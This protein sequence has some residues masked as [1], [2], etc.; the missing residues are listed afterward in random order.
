[1][2]R[3]KNKQQYAGREAKKYN[4]PV[5]PASIPSAQTTGDTA[6]SAK[7][8][9]WQDY[10]ITPIIPIQ[11]QTEI[12][13]GT[14]QKHNLA[15]LDVPAGF[16]TQVTFQSGQNFAVI[17]NPIQIPLDVLYK[18]AT[19]EPVVSSDM[20]Y[21]IATIVSRIGPYR[22]PDYPE[23]EKHVKGTL[24]C[25]N[26]TEVKRAMGTSCYMGFSVVAWDYGKVPT[27][28]R[29]GIIGKKHLP[30]N[31]IQF[32]VTPEGQI[33]DDYGVL[34]RYYGVV[35]NTVSNWGGYGATGINA[36]TNVGGSDVPIRQGGVNLTFVSAL[37]KMWRM[38]TTFNPQGYN[39]NPYGEPL[40]KK[41]YS[42][43]VSK[44]ANWAKIETSMTFKAFPLSIIETNTET[45]VV[46]KD[47]STAT[48]Q[49]DMIRN[50]EKAMSTGV[51]VTGYGINSLNIHT[52]DNS[53]DIEK[54]IKTIEL[55]DY[56]IRVAHCSSDF[57]SNNGTFASAKVNAD[58]QKEYK[59][60]IVSYFVDILMEQL[61][62]PTLHAGYGDKIENYGYF[63][64]LDTSVDDMLK[65]ANIFQAAMASGSYNPSDIE[66]LN[67]AQ[68][69]MGIYV[70][71]KPTPSTMLDLS[72]NK[73][74]DV[75]KTKEILN[76]PY[77]KGLDA[78]AK[79]DE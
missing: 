10:K 43:V 28:G 67:Y 40:T 68:R 16:S 77:S 33:D 66:Q 7:P 26:F 37:P 79:T 29:D 35:N 69:K 73:G 24:D 50:M 60:T 62:K 18:I 78:D 25:V 20:A 2:A 21:W 5:Q 39:G 22:N 32:A 46:Y 54:M 38:V 42:I 47:G 9:E 34:H 17:A 3:K 12:T 11:N 57:V 15:P 30:Q 13:F 74:G 4:Q 8:A 70:S 31:S 52:I 6:N 65:W 19:L 56:Q 76:E 45:T 53:A 75:S 58:S 55:C 44:W 27:T 64:L 71:D 36:I 63:E 23:Y 14:N 41:S 61:V 49:Q 51:L 48:A 1:M 72:S 59:N